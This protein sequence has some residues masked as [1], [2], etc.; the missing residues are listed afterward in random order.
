[1]RAVLLAERE[2]LTGK[3][4]SRGGSDCAG[5]LESIGSGSAA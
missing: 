5:D 4:A 2:S 1:M 3:K